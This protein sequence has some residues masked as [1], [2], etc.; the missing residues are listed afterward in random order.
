MEY[1]RSEAM[2]FPFISDIRVTSLQYFGWISSRTNLESTAFLWLQIFKDRSKKCCYLYKDSDDRLRVI[3]RLLVRII[4]KYDF[5][6]LCIPTEERPLRVTVNIFL[7]CQFSEF[8]RK[9]WQ[10]LPPSQASKAYPLCATLIQCLE[11][12]F[13]LLAHSA[14]MWSV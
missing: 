10:A 3:I 12:Y 14:H 11:N 13:S 8:Y 7:L 6:C 1:R 9:K 5:H 2:Q 4:C